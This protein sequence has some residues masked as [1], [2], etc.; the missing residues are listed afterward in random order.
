M[1]VPFLDIQAQYAGI[2]DQIK[3]AAARIIDSGVFT[4]VAAP[5]V[6]ELEAKL[7]EYCGVKHAIG[8][9]SGTDAI[10]AVLMALGIGAG[11]EV[12]VPTYTFFATAGCVWRVGAKPVFVDIEADTFNI[13]PAA[14]EAAIT[15]RTRAI[16]PVHLYGQTADMDAI[17]AIA[18]R[19]KLPVIEDA[20]QAIGAA[21]KGRKAG[22]MGTA[23]CF[24]F[25]PTKNLGALG[26]AGMVTA[27]DDALAEKISLLRNHGETSRYHHKYVGGNFRLDVLQAAALLV[28]LPLLEG[29]SAARRANAAK[30]DKL[31][32]DCPAIKTPVVRAGNTPIFNLYVIRAPRR[33]ELMAH[34]QAAGIGCGIYY[35]VPLHQQECFASLGGQ[36][37]DCPVAEQAAA[38][39]LA[40]PIFSELS[41]AQIEY[42]AAKVRE[43][44]NK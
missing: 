24:S 17:M 27:G 30:Y 35:P 32:A 36:R 29:W 18:A 9:S 8:V 34:L 6:K 20:A 1:K 44:Y 37:G 16:M 42:V 43:F 11:D 13:S 4:S 33:D 15:P 40:L 28:K 31:L 38:E 7:A 39:V 41:D 14:V 2:S 21:C 25:Y 5:A 19:H 3:A 12:I 10:I 22:S 23:G 26:D